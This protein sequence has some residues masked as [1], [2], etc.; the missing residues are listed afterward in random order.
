MRKLLQLLL[1]ILPLSAFSQKVSLLKDINTQDGDGLP[2][3]GIS[4]NNK[5]Y[6]AR[7]SPETGMELYVSDGTS[8]GTKLLKDIVDGPGHSY[9]SNFILF[10]GSV[11]FTVRNSISETELWK[12]NGTDVG[13]VKVSNLSPRESYAE[14]RGFAAATSRLYFFK[15]YNNTRT[16]Y[17][18]DGNS[19][20]FVKEVNSSFATNDFE[21]SA[22]IGNNLYFSNYDST[23]GTELWKSDGTSGGTALLKDLFTGTTNAT[24][25][26]LP[27]STNPSQLYNS[28]GRL[29][30]VGNA[31]DAGN[32]ICT[33][34]GT[35]NGTVILRTFNR[36]S[37]KTTGSTPS[38]FI[39][40]NGY[41]LFFADNGSANGLELWRTS[42]TIG[43]TVLVKDIY[44]GTQD[45]VREGNFFSFNNKLYFC[46]VTAENGQELWRSDG[47]SAGTNLFKEFEDGA[48]NGFT[49]SSFAATENGF[50]FSTSTTA[51]GKELYYSN[52][53]ADG[54]V[55]VKDIIPGIVGA[56][57]DSNGPISSLGEKVLFYARD[58]KLGY[59]TFVSDGTAEGTSML[60]NMNKTPKDSNPSRAV[61]L[62]GFRYFA[63]EDENGINVWKTDGTEA[64]TVMIKDLLPPIYHSSVESLTVFKGEVYFVCNSVLY[65]TDGTEGGTGK[66]ADF[67]V[68]QNISVYGEE[69][70]LIPF[71][72]YL[73]FSGKSYSS[74]IEYGF[75]L[76]RTDGTANGT[77]MVK[78]IAANSESSRP[79]AFFVY[80]DNL[81][82][83]SATSD[84]GREIWKTDGTEGGTSLVKDITSGTAGTFGLS[85]IESPSFIIAN[86]ALLF[87]T[88]DG[89]WKTDGTTQG[90]VLLKAQIINGYP[91][92]I[93]VGNKMYYSAS[94]NSGSTYE[95]YGTD[96]TEQG[97][98]A[99]ENYLGDKIRPYS[100]TGFNDK[101]FFTCDNTTHP[102]ELWSSDGTKSETKPLFIKQVLGASPG[103][104]Q[105]VGEN[106]VFDSYDGN[107]QYYL[108]SSD[109]TAAGT[110]KIFNDAFKSAINPVA[111]INDI[112]YFKVIKDTEWELGFTKGKFGTTYFTGYTHP[113][114]YDSGPKYP[115]ELN[116]KIIFTALDK[117]YG[118]ELYILDPSTVLPLTFDYFSAKLENEL[119]K[120]TWLT[121]GEKNVSHFVLERSGNGKDFMVLVTV[122]A[123]TSVLKGVYNYNDETIY[124]QSSRQLYYRLKQ[125]DLDGS[126]TFSKVVNVEL[127]VKEIFKAYPNPASDFVNITFTTSEGAVVMVELVDVYGRSVSKDKLFAS[128]G[129]NV[130][131]L[132]L[133]RYASGIYFVKVS[134]KKLDKVFKVLHN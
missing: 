35:S 133:K 101:L 97:T 64:G 128:V 91:L 75:E 88:N 11:Y 123:S 48:A 1:I 117:I 106:L 54:T 27:K 14:F 105:V 41:T 32:T 43:S 8:E 115:S 62:N 44:P 132:D 51:N 53:T 31:G 33:S 36:L 95:L 72:N 37:G 129:T 130:Y 98:L 99:I 7:S 131:R 100:F 111:V 120:L 94:V 46:G 87:R 16:L 84:A 104:L 83:T 38:G 50:F 113:D 102:G 82:F 103:K 80:N 9:P 4:F 70:I 59:E 47:T 40:V 66:V 126:F 60:L 49:F 29:F 110:K 19:L 76:C 67:Y 118:N 45:G 42:G 107:G 114:G 18:T 125:Y 15:Y 85:S 68:D 56:M 34:D 124:N 26:V 5:F 55:L 112:Y 90:T 21:S 63:A 122:N 86:S 61:T 78:D 17:Y 121:S 79:Y 25:V 73:Y 24:G 89:L 92:G 10:S 52:G 13:T 58:S 65:K 57:E 77:T 119:A 74:M 127:P 93:V 30:F 22:T 71:G 2:P 6:H 116:G 96:G 81:Y 12:T 108:C 28:N 134:G 20:T 3:I 23:N 109:G 69:S 39:Y